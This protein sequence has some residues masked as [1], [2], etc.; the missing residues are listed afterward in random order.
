MNAKIIQAIRKNII[1]R[2]YNHLYEKT[3]LIDNI[4][5]AI[6][7]AAKHKHKR[8]DVQRVLGNID[9]YAKRVHG[10][11]SD[12]SFEPSP[13][14]GH[15]TRDGSKNKE[16]EI[17]KP[18]YCYDQIMA[19]VLIQQLKP[20]ILKSM[21]HH[22]YG[23]LEGKGQLQVKKTLEKWIKNDP[24]GTKY[25]GQGDVRHF[26]P[27]VDQSILSEKLHNKI[28]DKDFLLECDKFVFRADSGLALGDPTSVWYGHFYLEE[29]DHF[30]VGLDG[31]DH[32]LRLMDDWVILGHNKKKLHKAMNEIRSYMF[33]K[34]NL[35][36]K[37]NYQ[38]FRLDWIDKN[39]NHQGRFLDI[40]GFRFYRD[41][42]I[43]R[44][45]IMIHATR[46]ANRITEKERATVHDARQMMSH[47]ARFKTADTYNVYESYIKGKVKP[48]LLRKTISTYDRKERTKWSGNM[49]RDIRQVDRKK[50]TLS[51]AQQL[52]T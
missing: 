47:L 39:G 18:K 6:Y 52:H 30:I 38:I 21:Y 17:A 37:F 34:L 19:H 40:D 28:K 35:Q 3:L 20:I 5:T 24:T 50:S 48:K 32:Y 43:L 14:V 12:H 9:E 4:K 45:N 44:K 15:I 31:V 36:L 42:T 46:K 7:D 16:R 22:V 1:M 26:Y 41:R 33:E 13:Y 11:L 23:S 27:S 51:Q 2:T 29:L 25:V 8:R 10:M 49:S